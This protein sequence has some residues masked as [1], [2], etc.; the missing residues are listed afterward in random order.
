[1]VG[2]VTV[3]SCSFDEA[4]RCFYVDSNNNDDV[5]NLYALIS[6]C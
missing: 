3:D 4:G 2:I 6:Y 5:I 1:M